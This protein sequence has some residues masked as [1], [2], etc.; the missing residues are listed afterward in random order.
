MTT[1]TFR[2]EHVWAFI[3]TDPGNGDEGIPAMMIGRTMCPLIGADES[4]LASLREM[5]Q[6]LV[7]MTGIKIRLVRFDS[8]VELGDVDGGL[9]VLTDQAGGD[10][11]DDPS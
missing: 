1:P 7:R 4:R 10:D 8:M 5:A 3:A 11:G 6:E 2:I 9:I